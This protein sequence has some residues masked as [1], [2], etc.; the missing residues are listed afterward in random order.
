MQW[1]IILPLFVLLLCVQ[2]IPESKHEGLFQLC[3]FIEDCEFTA[4][5]TR[6]LH[7]LGREGPQLMA[8]QPA[9][10]I[11]FIYNR[12]IL[13]NAAVRASAVSA[14]AKFATRCED[15]RPQIIPLLQRCTDDDEDEVRDRATTYLRL[16]GA[17]PTLAAP[18]TLE[19]AGARADGGAAATAVSA[20]SAAAVA[21]APPVDAGVSRVLTSG[22]LPLP[23]ASLSK[24]LHLYQLRPASGP[25][26]FDSLPHVEVPQPAV[27]PTG[28]LA[29]E[30]ETGGYGYLSETL[31]AESSGAAAKVARAK[32]RAATSAAAAA[33]AA[34]SGSAGDG[35]KGGA[36]GASAGAADSAAEALYRIPEFASFGALFRSSAPVELTERELEYLVSVQ[37]HIFE[38]HVVSTA[39][40]SLFCAR[41]RLDLLTAVLLVCHFVR[42]L[43][44]VLAFTVTNTVPEMLLERVTVALSL[45]EGEPGMYKPVLTLACPRIKEGTPGTVYTALA[46]NADAGFGDVAYDVELRFH[47]RE[48][49]PSRGY[50]PIGD[51]MPETYPVNALAITAADYVARTPVGDF[52]T[53][54]EQ[55]GAEGEVLESFVLSAKSV[56]EAAAGVFEALGLAPCENTGTVKAGATKHGAF[57]SGTFLGDVKVLAR[58]QLTAEAGEGGA[59]GGGCLLKI[60]IRSEDRGVSELLLSTIS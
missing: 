60:A 39:K 2:M 55:L 12:I 10:F 6:V 32:A 34:A 9:A 22:L 5:A 23:V 30:R 3:E 8:P 18:V 38:N 41:V 21:P 35:A 31:T 42:V 20:A 56:S 1:L 40:F 58:L 28:A 47:S 17:Q 16:L 19:K 15:L 33:D 51:A 57:L 53:A 4:L 26:S 14:L 59:A 52:R 27:P 48:C 46:R 29:A 24:A 44:Q 36:G 45:A 37:K 11:R 50:E 49:D 43:V 54:W 7:L 25:F 13:E